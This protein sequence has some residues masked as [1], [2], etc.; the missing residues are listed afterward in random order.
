MSYKQVHEAPVAPIA[1][2]PKVPPALSDI[3][4]RCLSKSAAARYARGNELAD[5]LIAFLRATPDSSA[6]YRAAV[7]A[8]RSG[9]IVASR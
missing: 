1:A 7:T 6:P 4:M 8:R 2:N 5:A 3:V 9:G